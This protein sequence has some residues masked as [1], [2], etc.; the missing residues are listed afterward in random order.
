VKNRLTHIQMRAQFHEQN[1]YLNRRFVVI[2]GPIGVGK[3]S[4]ARLL[5]DRWKCQALF[6]S[7]E[8]NPFLTSGFYEKRGDYAFN[9][10]V[11]FLLSRFR[12]IRNLAEEG[13][14]RVSDYL[15]DKNA[16]FS[17]MNL[18]QQDW[19]I[20]EPLYREF[21]NRVPEPDLIVYLTADI[22][23]LTKRVYLRDR[24]FERTMSRDYLDS[25]RVAYENYFESYT[26]SPVVRVNAAD[27]D[28]V[29]RLTD[30]SR[31]AAL[32]EDRLMGVRQLSF[33]NLTHPSER[34][35]SAS[36]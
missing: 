28:F 12:Q 6:E 25:L 35:I 14:T 2:E 21:S 9:T 22:D 8:D 7:F 1:P 32:I 11:F 18:S 34:V 10:E 16:I 27:F 15:F 20:Y 23:T 36:A 5:A 24:H 13:E 26:R 17:K 3:T 30:F 4:L 19:D 31:M 29:N 33:E